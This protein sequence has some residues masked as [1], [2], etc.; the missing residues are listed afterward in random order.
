MT[1][2]KAN[3][4]LFDPNFPEKEKSDFIR[5][6]VAGGYKDEMSEEFAQKFDNWM[7]DLN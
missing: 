4:E 7:A 3:F 6:G 1:N 5:K 2:M